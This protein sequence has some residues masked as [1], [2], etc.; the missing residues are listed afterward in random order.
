MN[1]K[2]AYLSLVFV[3]SLWF[4]CAPERRLAS[5]MHLFAGHEFVL[6]GLSHF[7][8]LEMRNKLRS[9]L[10]PKPN[11][12]VLGLSYELWLY[13]RFGKS[14]SALLRRLGAAP[15]WFEDLP[16]NA[17]REAIDRYLN[18]NGFLDYALTTVPDTLANGRIALKHYI[19]CP[20]PYVVQHFDYELQ[21]ETEELDVHLLKLAQN[22]T[23]NDQKFSYE[24]LSGLRMQFFDSLRNSGFFYLQESNLYFRADTNSNTRTVQ[25]H[26][27]RDPALDELKL[28]R[29]K[30][31]RLDISRLQPA[32]SA[33]SFRHGLWIHDEELQ[34]EADLWARYVHMRPGDWFSFEKQEQSRMELQRLGL[35]Q[36]LQIVWQASDTIPNTLNGMLILEPADRYWLTVRLGSQYDVRNYLGPELSVALTD[37]KFLGRAASLSTSASVS[38][39]WGLQPA[40]ANMLSD[41]FINA[42]ARVGVQIPWSV[43]LFANRL[44]RKLNS[45]TDFEL[46]YNYLLHPF[47]FALH[48]YSFSSGYEWSGK[49]TEY[50]FRMLQAEY[51]RITKKSSLFEGREAESRL[52]Q[53]SYE[54]RM[55]LGSGMEWRFRNVP[56]ERKPGSKLFVRIEESGNLIHIGRSLL[57]IG[58]WADENREF[59]GVAYAQYVLAEFDWTRRIA[60]NDDNLLVWR[61]AAGLGRPLGNSSALPFPKRF[62]VGGTNSI[63]AFKMRSVGPGGTPLDEE[64]LYI[65]QTGDMKFEANLEMRHQLNSNLELALFLDAGNVWEYKNATG[66]ALAQFNPRLAI[67][68]LA[69][70]GGMGLRIRTDYFVLRLD[71]ALPFRNPALPAE[72]RWVFSRQN[73]EY[74]LWSPRVIVAIGYPF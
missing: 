2:A 15:V 18:Y 70:G 59:M 8:S 68:Q 43:G 34:K 24:A 54:S 20:K 39:E 66:E 42:S 3:A 72:N 71:G 22:L 9:L 17:H 38:T 41:R 26:L 57:G 69:V 74:K 10:R 61:L 63:R 40:A 13:T 51:F 56:D 6:Y 55:I 65:E 73:L 25:L 1:W 31:G 52:L 45:K 64:L 11:Q 62:Y 60:L 35:V 53:R 67:G 50:N 36:S 27:L 49:R 14:R 4:G 44:W 7:D 47:Y 48:N 5:D 21:T 29:M 23:W 32:D 19:F 12:Q 33:A 28:R 37:N 30:V 58:N 46:N 16:L